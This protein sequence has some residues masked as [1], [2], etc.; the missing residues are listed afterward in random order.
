MGTIVIR[1]DGTL[2]ETER[3]VTEVF[4]ALGGMTADLP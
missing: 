1:T 2:A 3:Q 4:R